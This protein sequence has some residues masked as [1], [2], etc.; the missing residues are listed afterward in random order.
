MQVT[1]FLYASLLSVAL[2]SLV[3]SCGD[4]TVSN[5]G[6]DVM[7]RQDSVSTA[8]LRF[9]VS[10]RTVR[11]PSSVA[12][13]NSSW[14]GSV[15]DPETG[16]RTTNDFVAQFYVPETFR[17]PSR[18]KMIADTDGLP[19]A[20]SC[21]LNIYHDTYYGD[22]FAA[23][24]V[25]V[26]EV[27]TART[28]DEKVDY[29]TQID[30]KKLLLTGAGAEQQTVNYSVFDQTRPQSIVQGNAYYRRLAIPLSKDFATRILRHYYAH[31]EHFANSYQFAHHVCGGF[32]F[33]HSGGIGAMLKSDFVTLDLHF[34][35]R[36]K[37]AAGADTLVNGSQRFTAT[38]E[39]IQL[40]RVEN[41]L[42]EA[43]LNTT[44]P[45]TYVK[46]PLALHTEA[47]LPID[48]VVGGTHYNDT[49][50]SASLNLRTVLEETDEKRLPKP[51]MLLLVRANDVDR[52]FAKVQMV[53]GV[54]SYVAAYDKISTTTQKATYG[55]KYD[56]IGRLIAYIRD[57]RDRGAGVK[58]TDSE[59]ERK[60]KWA[61]WEQANPNWNKV[62]LLPVVGEYTTTTDYRSQRT[63]RTLVRVLN[64]FD[65][66]SARLEGGSAGNV[67]LSVV[68]SRFKK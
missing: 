5:L 35:Y 24:K 67:E 26:R 30:A 55:Y 7:P 25:T 31:P 32:Y 17:L 66:S 10:T 39:I 50:N 62:V 44:L 63:V 21:F 3:T 4:E 11:T 27:D 15:I 28:L 49:I 42:P 2:G 12:R 56:N 8:Q 59:T 41:A 48:D 46:S 38:D 53:D 9:P 52:F 45:Y 20:D 40:P 33:Q 64:A 65:L 6:I 61:A 1:T 14:L 57:E 19:V 54:T 23:Q 29:T 60:A 37:T 18:E 43:M 58:A 68:Y 34:R 16:A 13:S 51:Q 22:S 47:T 36:S